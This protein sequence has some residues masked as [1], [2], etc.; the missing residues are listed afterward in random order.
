MVRVAINGFGRI[1]RTAFIIALDKYSKDIEIVAVNDL[2]DAKTLAHLLKYDSN[3]G[4]WK[5]DIRADE[6]GIIVDQK[7]I[8]VLNIREP[9]KLPWKD[10]RVDIVVESTG[11]FT[12]AE[13]A[14]KHLKAGAKRVIVSAPSKDI[15]TFILGVNGTKYNGEEVINN[16]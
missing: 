7:A 5:R 12:E 15:P 1:G 4:L 8:E 2:S 6:K 10:L 9:D 16:A 11:R 13:G 3:Y 14:R